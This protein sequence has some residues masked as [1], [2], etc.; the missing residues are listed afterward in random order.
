M[1]FPYRL[2][3]LATWP[4]WPP[5][6]PL[7]ATG[8]LLSIRLSPYPSN[9]AGKYTPSPQGAASTANTSLLLLHFSFLPRPICYSKSRFTHRQ[10]CRGW[11]VFLSLDFDFGLLFLL[12]SVWPILLWPKILP[13]FLPSAPENLRMK[14]SKHVLRNTRH[15]IHVKYID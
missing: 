15:R 3:H 4:L 2:R 10:A 8:F 12:V 14:Y 11:Y 6:G 9:P 13:G 1:S 5:A 7:V